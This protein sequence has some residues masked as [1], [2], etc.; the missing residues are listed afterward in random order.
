RKTSRP[1]PRRWPTWPAGLPKTCAPSAPTGA[2]TTRATWTS[3]LGSK[4]RSRLSTPRRECRSSLLARAGS[5]AEHVADC[6]AAQ[7]R[8]PLAASEPRVELRGLADFE[9]ADPGI[10]RPAL[11]DERDRPAPRQRSAA[12]VDNVVAVEAADRSALGENEHRCLAGVADVGETPAVR[13]VPLVL[14][15]H[16]LIAA[17]AG[18]RV[19]VEPA[20]KAGCPVR[21]QPQRLETG[22]EQ[23]QRH[24][25]R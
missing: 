7:P 10:R 18:E 22:R 15:Q 21:L 6:R 4:R 19:K 14:R 2:S 13:I 3:T 11:P 12:V 9:A 17:R 16:D 23:G 25:V 20:R 1:W 24:E 8:D 5:D